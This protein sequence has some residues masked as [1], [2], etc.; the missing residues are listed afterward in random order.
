MQTAYILELKD[1]RRLGNIGTKAQKLCFLAQKKFPIPL[2]YVCTWDAYRR[3]TQD[4]IE[5]IEAI[6]AEL[7]TKIDTSKHYAVR[8]S[9]NI[10]D[11]LDFSFAGQFKSLLNMRGIDDILQAIW[12]IWQ[13][14]QSPGVQAYLEKNAIDPGTIKMA[15]IIQEMVS[16]LVSGVS[17]SKNPMTGMDEIIVEAVRGSGEALVQEGVTPERWINKW[18]EWIARPEP[19]GENVGLDLVQ[20]VVHQTKAIARAY[21]RP[22]DL[23]W[24]YD[25]HTLY[26]VQL[27]EITT[28][29]INL[30]SNRIS[31]EFF[32]GIIKPLVWSVNVPLVNGAWVRLFTELIGP[33]DIDPNS[34]AKSFYYRAYFNM[35][36]VGQI[37][38]QLGLPRE[39]LELLAGIEMGGPEKPSFKPSPKTYSFLPRMLRV[40]ID[41][42]S[43]GP[44]IEAFL[45]TA[46]EQYQTFRPD[47]VDRLTE[48]E[49]VDEIDRLYTLTQRVAYYNIVTP[50]LMQIYNMILK[51]QLNRIGV[52]FE[53]FDLIGDLEQLQQFDPNV[54]LTRLNQK[55]NELDKGLQAHVRQSNY[56][57]FCQLPGIE[58]LHKEVEQF[59]GQFGHLS[60]SGNDFSSE[61]WR[62]NP[63]LILNMVVNYTPLEDRSL[64]K[65]D[66]R[67]LKISPFRR[68][69]LGP[70]YRRARQFQFYRETIG[71]LYTFCYGLFRIYFLALGDRFQKRGLI[72]SREDIFY[73]YFNQVRDTVNNN[74]TASNCQETIAQRKREIEDYR[75]IVPPTL[76]YGEEALPLESQA[77]QKLSGTPTS[78]G[79]YTGPARVVQGIRD[80][81]KLKDGDVLV[82]PYSDVGWTPLFTRAGA[83]IAESGGILSHS[84][85]IAREYNIPAVVSVPGACSLE[86]DTLVTVDGYRG[87]I[88]IHEPPQA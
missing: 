29:N 4:D 57:E 35:G 74:H 1:A 68:L 84:S 64:A 79:L 37:L 82:I 22:V 40:A 63:D 23:E 5:V 88:V 38:E 71:F 75:D 87:K 83:V 72:A 11:K 53:S 50:L 66:F 31:K 33:N 18:G 48:K 76:I 16:P 13:K 78:R 56:G 59:I 51:N 85:I 65:T 39:T 49:L 12:T 14:I 52:D 47:Q 73:L 45:P 26:W 17:F 15:I 42:L 55:Y 80:F 70:I 32:P 60:D 69:L 20:R 36:A 34:L 77:S 28:L 67:D 58:S 81:D 2:T 43:F 62:E 7:S 6:K 9:A 3:Y 46:K 19:E 24:V 21:G 30:Y 86:D 10:E 25:G 54:H 61:P 44:K 8:S 41:K 27:R